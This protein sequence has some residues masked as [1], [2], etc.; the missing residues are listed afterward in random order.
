MM[1]CFIGTLYTGVFLLDF[2]LNSNYIKQDISLSQ[3]SAFYVWVVFKKQTIR[4]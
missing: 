2:L 4:F 3:K 1:R